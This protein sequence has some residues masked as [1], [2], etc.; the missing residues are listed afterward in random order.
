MILG[1]VFRSC[2]TASATRK[3]TRLSAVLGLA[4]DHDLTSS[5]LYELRARSLANVPVIFRRSLIKHNM[6]TRPIANPDLP[7]P[8]KGK[9]P[10]KAH[11]KR[12]AKWIAENGGPIGGVIYLEGTGTHM[13]EVT[14]SDSRKL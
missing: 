9:Y 2:K 3:P 13:T 7:A 11:C 6:A 8:P 4:R 10:A 5:N 1:S 14:K 12:V